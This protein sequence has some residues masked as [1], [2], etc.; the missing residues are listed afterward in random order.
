MM[1]PGL[2]AATAAEMEEKHPVLPVGLTQ[3]AEATSDGQ[4]AARK[5]ARTRWVQTVLPRRLEG[6]LIAINMKEFLL[7]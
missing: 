3:D 7:A 1:A 6:R 5:M 2:A 4:I